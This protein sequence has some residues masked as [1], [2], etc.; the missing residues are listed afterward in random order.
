MTNLTLSPG[1][2][3]A[4]CCA[5]GAHAK[6]LTKAEA[7]APEN[8]IFR[9]PRTVVPSHYDLTITPGPESRIFHGDVAINVD[10]L[11]PTSVVK[12]NAKN[13]VITSALARHESGTVL[14]GTVTIDADKEMAE[15]AFAGT[16]AASAW[17]LELEFAGQ[18]GNNGQGFFA[19]T[20]EDA[21]KKVRAGLLMAA[22][23]KK[24]ELKITDAD[25][26]AG[27]QELAQEAGKNV[28]KM[29]TE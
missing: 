7:A 16:L 13:L 9:L 27:I 19:N 29:R 26:E 21:E 10:V 2:H 4:Q 5:S 28:A 18:H 23:A 12:I 22:I 14:N 17:V 24:L 11:K 8:N 20:W 1:C 3:H 6:A 15:I 25:I